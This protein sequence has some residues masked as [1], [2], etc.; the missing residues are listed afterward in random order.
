MTG[1]ESHASGRGGAGGQDPLR[2]GTPA[3][4]RCS[5]D[6]GGDTSFPLGNFSADFWRLELGRCSVPRKKPLLSVGLEKVA[7]RGGDSTKGHRSGFNPA[8]AVNQPWDP[9]QVISFL[10]PAHS[11]RTRVMSKA[12]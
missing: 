9:G 10:G 3:G 2:G 4:S 7:Q 8:S 1:W 5:E 12:N 11:H 6:L